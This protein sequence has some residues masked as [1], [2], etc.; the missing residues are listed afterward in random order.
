MCTALYY[1]ET[2]KVERTFAMAFLLLLLHS[3]QYPEWLEVNQ[4]CGITCVMFLIVYQLA[5]IHSLHKTAA[6]AASPTAAAA[7][8]PAPTTTEVNARSSHHHLLSSTGW[9]EAPLI[10]HPAN[11]TTNLQSK[12]HDG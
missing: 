10:H 2:N 6:A 3:Q 5:K 12:P 1:L 9:K 11:P 8:H 7:Q 4:A